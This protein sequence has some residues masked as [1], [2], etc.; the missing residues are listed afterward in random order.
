[1]E[2]C[3]FI[4]LLRTERAQD[5]GLN[6]AAQRKSNPR[7][8]YIRDCGSFLEARWRCQWGVEGERWFICGRE[9]ECERVCGDAEMW[10][11]AVTCYSN[12]RSLKNPEA[13]TFR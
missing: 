2:H 8:R 11:T 4:H 7:S 1:M 3:A 6:M 10:V 12:V 9:D 5:R 13:L